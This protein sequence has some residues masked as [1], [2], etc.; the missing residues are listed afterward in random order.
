[1]LSR[2]EAAD[3]VLRAL[4]LVDPVRAGREHEED[5]DEHLER[6]AAGLRTLVDEILDP[7]E[8]L[9]PLLDSDE[10]AGAD[11]RRLA[12]LLPQV[13][14]RLWKVAERRLDLVERARDDGPEQCPDQ[15]QQPDVVQEDPDGAGD[16]TAPERLD[17]RPHGG[18][19][20]EAEEEQREDQLELPEREAS[21]GSQR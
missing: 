16:S 15:R 3:E 19:H 11:A 6:D 7:G 8:L 17:S 14:A 13:R 12:R 10:H 1:M 20:D 4:A 21:S 5:P 18:G 2:R 9:Q